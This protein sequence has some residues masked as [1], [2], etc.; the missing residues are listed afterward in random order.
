MKITIND[1]RKISEIQEEFNRHFPYLRLG[2]SFKPLIS[3]NTKLNE[4]C[5]FCKDGTIS[6]TPDMTVSDLELSF[7]NHYGLIVQVLR[8]SGKAWLETTVTDGWT[9]RKQNEQGEALSKIYP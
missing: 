5:R 3:E 1:H 2:F 6:I 4:C 8:K 9:L 7:Y